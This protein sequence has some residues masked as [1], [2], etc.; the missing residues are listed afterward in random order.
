MDGTRGYGK[1]SRKKKAL[2]KYMYSKSNSDCIN[3]TRIRNE[4]RAMPRTLCAIFEHQLVNDVKDNP[5]TF[6]NY[7]RSKTKTKPG[8]SDLRKDNGSLTSADLENG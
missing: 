8:V 6:W 2:E 3:D 5:D 1:S 4:L 7:A